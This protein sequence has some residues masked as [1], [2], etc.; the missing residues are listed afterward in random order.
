MEAQAFTPVPLAEI[1]TRILASRRITRLDQKLLLSQGYLTYEEQSLINQV[2]DRLRKG[3][4]KVV[5]E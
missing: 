5:D 2:F 4:L 1:V 3:F